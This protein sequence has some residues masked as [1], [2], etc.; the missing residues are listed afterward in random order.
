MENDMFAE[1]L[2]W[3]CIYPHWFNDWWN[4]SF[5]LLDINNG[6]SSNWQD[7][8]RQRPQQT[9]LLCL[10][11]VISSLVSFF[12]LLLALQQEVLAFRLHWCR[13]GQS[14]SFT[15]SISLDH[16]HVNRSNQP[17]LHEVFTCCLK[18]STADWFFRN[19]CIATPC[20]G[21]QCIYFPINPL[22][23]AALGRSC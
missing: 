16:F 9:S 21:L 5:S 7:A 12:L 22:N 4:V 1:W 2:C 17:V 8:L 19:V 11:S 13:W 6:V 3:S 10:Q 15:Q 20:L 14:S 23:W 18:A